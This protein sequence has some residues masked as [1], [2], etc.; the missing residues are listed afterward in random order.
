MW[1]VM[2]HRFKEVYGNLLKAWIRGIDVHGTGCVSKKQFATACQAVN[3]EYDADRLFDLLR[4]ENGRKYMSL[5][6]FDIKAY[7]AFA[8]NDF[9][10]LSEPDPVPGEERRSPLDMTLNERTDSGFFFQIRRAWKMTKR[11]K[12][13]KSCRIYLPE[14]YRVDTI[15]KFTDLCIRKYGSMVSAWRFG[16]D[17]E[18]NGR[19]NFNEFCVAVRRIGYMGSLEQLWADFCGPREDPSS[20][21]LI[22][23]KMLDPV[24]DDTVTRFCNILHERFEDL[25]TLWLQVFKKDPFSSISLADLTAACKELGFPEEQCKQLFTS[26]Q[27]VAGERDIL[28]LWDLEGIFVTTRRIWERSKPRNMRRQVKPSGTSL[29]VAREESLAAAERKAAKNVP[30]ANLEHGLSPKLVRMAF[31]RDHVS[32]VNAWNSELDWRGTGVV[33]WGTFLPFAEQCGLA[34]NVKKLWAELTGSKATPDDRGVLT[35]EKLDPQ[36][37]QLI[38]DVRNHLLKQ[39]G[40][41]TKAW[42][43][44]FDPSAAGHLDEQDFVGMCEKVLPSLSKKQ[45]CTLFRYLLLRHGQRSVKLEHLKPLLIGLDGKEQRAAAWDGGKPQGKGH[46]AASANSLDVQETPEKEKGKERDIDTLEGFKGM[47]IAKYGSFF[48]AWKYCLD[49]D[50]NG[51]VSQKDFAE[52]CRR[53]GVI[54]VLPVWNTICRGS[55]KRGQITLKDL[56]PETAEAWA[57]FHR[58]VLKASLKVPAASPTAAKNNDPSSPTSP[59]NTKA[60]TDD[61]ASPNSTFHKTATTNLG[62]TAAPADSPSRTPKP[63]LKAGWRYAFDPQNIKRIDKTRFCQG[64]AEIGYSQDP[65][66]LY[67][68]LKPDPFREYLVYQDLVIDLN[69]NNFDT[70]SFVQ[71]TYLP[72]KTNT[73]ELNASLLD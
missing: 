67:E 6:D 49:R 38:T 10:M 65:V 43:E 25:A 3:F 27:P 29:I 45:A 16:L 53:L 32:T 57:E 36:A 68:L 56:D 40:T 17:P 62:A 52:A 2:R 58:L 55:K 54:K 61:P 12:F 30:W 60:E 66:R 64:C 20:S 63:S 15:E 47:I 18:G 33:T 24:G 73:K 70:K 72:V 21:N 46:G 37:L 28:F 48:A 34:G 1:N 69:P 26:L 19:L 7:K 22:T 31:A 4:P 41:L 50:H 23:L 51:V 14:K 59:S 42:N 71:D 39:Y 5:F 9:R 13:A 11:K 8:R 44:G 35:F